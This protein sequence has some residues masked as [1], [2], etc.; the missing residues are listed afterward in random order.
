MA[1]FRTEGW[2]AYR[3]PASKGAVDVIAL[4]NGEIRLIQIKST[5][6]PGSPYTDFGPSAR[7][8]LLEEADRAGGLASFWHYGPTGLR[9]FEPEEWPGA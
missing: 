3:T 9:V 5:R 4:R 2:A 8:R 6:N 7:T 1:R